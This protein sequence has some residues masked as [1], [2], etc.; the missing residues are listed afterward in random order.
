MSVCVLALGNRHANLVFSTQYFVCVCV[1]VWP[2]RLYHIFFSTLSHKLHDFRGK[3]LTELKMCF[4][5]L[6]FCLKK[7]LILRRIQ[8]D[9][10]NISRSSGKVHDILAGC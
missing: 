6:Y 5:F 1:C 3:K 2:V 10:I 8:R 7:F 9:I 4:G